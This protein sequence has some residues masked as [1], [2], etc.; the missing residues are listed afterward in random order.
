M[1]KG[2]MIETGLFSLIS[3]SLMNVRIGLLLLIPF[4]IPPTI[5]DEE[6][7]KKSSVEMFQ[8]LEGIK[9]S[10]EILHRNF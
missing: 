4:C 3:A 8:S 1:E 5:V 9:F 6:E 10:I 2:V 7:K